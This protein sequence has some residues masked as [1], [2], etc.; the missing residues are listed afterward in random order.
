M[1]GSTP[2]Y[3]LPY[4]VHLEADNQLPATILA[5]SWKISR[6]E[7]R[8]RIQQGG[9]V[10]LAGITQR[11]FFPLWQCQWIKLTLDDRPFPGQIWRLVDSPGFS[12]RFIGVIF[13]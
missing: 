9:V 13:S 3:L 6:G 10:R 12:G 2:N 11:Y 5:D 1:K 7:A 8:K 4:R